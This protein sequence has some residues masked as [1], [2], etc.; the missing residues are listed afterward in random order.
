[1]S[2][3]SRRPIIA[4]IVFVLVLIVL[5]LVFFTQCNKPE[6]QVATEPA[7]SIKPTSYQEPEAI[8]AAVEREEILT[9][10]TIQIPADVIAGA[11]FPVQWTGPENPKDY[12]TITLPDASDDQYGDYKDIKHGNPTQLN[13]PI[14]AGK[15]EVRYVAHRSKKVLGRSVIQVMPAE[16]TLLAVDEEIQGKVISVEW[17][18]P[19]NQG[20]YITVVPK[21]TEDGKYENYTPTSSGSPLS[22]KL[23]MIIGEVELRYMTGQGAKVL[24]RRPLV[25]TTAGVTLSAPEECV[26]GSEFSVEWS[27]PGNQGDYITIVLKDA[28]DGSYGNYTNTSQASTLVITALIEP[29]DAEIRYMSGQGAQVLARIPIRIVAAEINLEAP[30]HAE[31]KS[32]VSIEWTGPN[33]KGDYI[34]IVPKETPEGQYK[35]YANTSAGSPLSIAAPETSGAAEIRYVSGQGSKVLKRRDIT[36]R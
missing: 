22:L 28:A 30:P 9:P 14:E 15:Y 3:L 17:T 32:N 7:Q 21:D 25:I 31:A 2:N 1:M 19:N 36:I 20:D 23:P 5:L 29:G 13:A 12:L 35:A 4:V 16:A 18:G 6:A 11:T 24:A 34:T 33:N 26:A 10:A 8:T 27:G